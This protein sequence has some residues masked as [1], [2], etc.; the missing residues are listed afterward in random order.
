MNLIRQWTQSTFFKVFVLL[1]V[2]MLLSIALGSISDVVYERKNSQR[3]AEEELAETYVGAQTFVSPVLVIPYLEEWVEVRR[4]S[5]GKVI[6]RDT[7]NRTH[8][9]P[10]M[11][12]DIR[13][14]G[15]MTP[16]SRYRGIF[17]VQFYQSALAVSG[18][19]PPLPPAQ[20]KK[21]HSSSTI[22]R[23]QPWITFRLSDIRGLQGQPDTAINGERL[24]FSRGKIQGAQQTRA[25]AEAT[26]S[27]KPAAEE[28]VSEPEH[29]QATVMA[30][31][32]AAMMQRAGDGNCG[33]VC[34]LL[35]AP[36]TGK[37][38]QDFRT[39]KP[40]QLDM[41]IRFAGQKSLF[42][43]PVANETS[44]QLQS[45]WQHPS[46][47]G[48]FLPATR[49]VGST[50]F[51]SNWNISSLITTGSLLHTDSGDSDNTFGVHLIQPINTYSLSERAMK[52]GFL[53]VAL[54]LMVVFM[55]ELFRRLRLH[56]MQYGLVGLSISLFFL[57]LL[58]LSEK[59]GF[60][61]AYLCAG[62]ATVILLGIYF[63]A[64]LS[65]RMHGLGMAGFV[66]LLYAALYGLLKSE[67]NALLLGTLLL[68]TLLSALMLMTR[69]VNWYALTEKQQHNHTPDRRTPA[70][71]AA[72]NKDA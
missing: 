57:L 6:A 32:E 63:S 18:N 54:T 34:S 64:I 44:V 31:A 39:G 3:Y 47:A 53:F 1:F 33:L 22:T 41:T 58:A 5:E 2:L 19:F 59:I 62:S 30:A 51:T 40:L 38:L 10:V 7:N 25:S 26:E 46:F 45:D 20:F 55:V 65:R 69:H 21:Q 49:N 52:Y 67:D 28:T 50:G 48:S 8:L 42:F 35:R 68:F 60:A 13:I 16:E 24:A 9:Q 11:A 66:A 56:P 61:L 4:N 15:S 17:E 29:R 36:L 14:S 70:T 37:A 27:V 12:T 72:E 23:G 43:A 71:Q